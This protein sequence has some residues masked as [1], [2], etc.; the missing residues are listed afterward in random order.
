MNAT[1]TRRKSQVLI[2]D[3]GMGLAL[4]RGVVAAAMDAIISVDDK[5]R[6]LFFNPAAERMF[7]RTAKA[8]TDKPLNL[9]LPLKV[10]GALRYSIQELS[11]TDISTR[12]VGQLDELCGL[13][14]DGTAFAIEASIAQVQFGAKNIFTVIVRDVSEHKRTQETL[15]Q[16]AEY[17]RLL[18]TLQQ[19][20]LV[21]P[22]SEA[23][24]QIVL[25]RL[26]ELN[27][28]ARSAI[29]LPDAREHKLVMLATHPE[30]DAP[31]K[32]RVE[33]LLDEYQDKR[34]PNTAYVSGN[35]ET[36]SDIRKAGLPRR[37]AQGLAQVKICAVL[38][39]PLN[40]GANRIGVLQLYAQVP[41]VPTTAELET[42]RQVADILAVAL[43][44]ARLHEVINTT[45]ERLHALTRRQLELEESLRRKLSRELHDMVGQ[46]LTALNINLY[47]LG[48]KLP[49]DTPETVRTRLSDSSHLV[50][51]IV[52]RIRNLM[53]ELR[54]SILD[55]LGLTS[56]LRWYA[57]EFSKRTELP[58]RVTV[59]ELAPRLPQGAET[60]LFRIAQEAL[61]NVAKHAHAQTVGVE[62]QRQGRVVQL[63]VADD[64]DGFDFVAMRRDPSK[65]GVGI[66]DM[67]E[68][69]EAIGGRMWVE[70]TPGVGTKVQV[71]VP[72]LKHD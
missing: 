66:V 35:L 48:N 6:I 60:A 50:E 43:Q 72:F 58:M 57:G 36:I 14:A 45:R 1:K 32:T 7:G 63:T 68:R 51:E 29:L 41:H 70:C 52:E 12:T 31:D 54:P 21:A 69:A 39:V 24:A 25:N 37:L 47:A 65:H 40:V 17:L 53:A 62:L 4:Y 67:R 49:A 71:Q 34:G 19:S 11:R 20:I 10:R 22:S 13:R 33:G 56:A 46:N 16:H 61:T 8:V 59:Q 18:N 42:A 38:D 30:M 27:G 28:Y 9:L 15:E 44:Q 3:T 23:I 5:Q 2:Q 64:G 55:D 26:S